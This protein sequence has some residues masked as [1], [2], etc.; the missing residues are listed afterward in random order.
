MKHFSDQ[1]QSST[2][3]EEYRQY[4]LPVLDPHIITCKEEPFNQD[5]GETY[6]NVVRYQTLNVSKTEYSDTRNRSGLHLV[7]IT[8][9]PD[10]YKITFDYPSDDTDNIK[11]RTNDQGQ[12]TMLIFMPRVPPAMTSI[13]TATNNYDTGYASLLYKVRSLHINPLLRHVTTS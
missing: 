11:S 5:K 9:A 13:I 10:V 6:S 8:G 2:F 4:C 1:V 3:E 12:G 7:P